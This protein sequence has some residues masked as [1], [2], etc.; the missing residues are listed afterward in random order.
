MSMR[1]GLTCLLAALVTFAFMVGGNSSAQAQKLRLA[2]AGSADLKNL[3][4]SVAFQHA[5]ERGVDYDLV[6]LKSD[7]I[8]T[9]AIIGKQV[10]IVVSSLGYSAIQALNAPFRH[11]MQ[12]RRL[13]FYPVVAADT[14][15]SWSE[16]NGKDF[17]VHARGSGTEIAAHEIE[18]EN[19]IKFAHLTYLPVS[20][21]RANALLHG[22]IKATL[23]DIEGLQYVMRMAPNKFVVLPTPNVPVSEA[24]LYAD[25]NLLA[26]RHDQVEILVEEL[27]KAFRASAA[28]PNYIASERKRLNINPGLA[29]ERV[30]Q[31]APF[32]REAAKQN[33]YPLNGGGEAA[34]KADIDFYSQAGMLKG[35]A[36]SMKVADFWDFSI[37]NAALG[38]VGKVKTAKESAQ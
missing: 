21:V 19:K 11:F 23:L 17:V 34:A 14:A 38:K 15:R 9:Q 27:L 26:K 30:A 8:A 3:I 7:D 1:A 37:L 25:K 18:K 24:A 32:Y 4:D 28:D 10:D 2:E 22:V 35:D 12:L 13:K 20:Q 5:K 36:G 33:V 31:I 6:Y 29:P 16:M